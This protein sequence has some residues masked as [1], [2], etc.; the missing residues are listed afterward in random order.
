M[1]DI[2]VD[3]EQTHDKQLAT[4]QRKHDRHNI[5]L[6]ITY[7]DGHANKR[8]REDTKV[9]YAVREVYPVDKSG[10]EPDMSQE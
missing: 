8:M 6:K 3:T 1:H 7:E 10:R 2:H 4:P 5:M 9:R